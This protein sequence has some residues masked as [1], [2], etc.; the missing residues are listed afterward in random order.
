MAR[1]KAHPES[2]Q[3][4]VKAL[5]LAGESVTEAARQLNLDHSV[6]SRIKSGL[7]PEELHELARKKSG[8]IEGLLYDYLTTTL[9]SLKAQ[10]EVAGEREYIIKQPASE[11][12]LLHGT[13]ADKAVR[14]LEA[15]ARAK[16]NAPVTPTTD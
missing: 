2:T 4:Q 13:M 15:A 3:A 12:Y 10:A 16:N 8:E 1:G 6:V 9:A 5:L 14:L 7:T 11:L